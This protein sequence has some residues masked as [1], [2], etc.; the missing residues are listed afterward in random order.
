MSTIIIIILS[1]IA[2]ACCGFIF[3]PHIMRYCQQHHIYDIPN[4]RKIHK[5]NIPRL[6][7]ISFLPSMLLAFIIGM[8]VLTFVSENQYPTISLWSCMFLVSLLLIYFM[9]IVD[10]LIGLGANIKF[11]GQLIASLLMPLAGLYLNNLYGLFGVYQLPMYV[12]I[13]VTVLAIVFICNAINLIDGIDG[14][15]SSLCFLALGG[16]LWLF[17]SDGL[18]VYAVMIAGMMGAL[19]PFAYYNLF[20]DIEKNMKVF[21]GDS[22]SLTLGF[23]LGFLFVKYSMNNLS[24]M[25]YRPDALIQAASLLIVPCFDVFRIVFVRYWHHRSLFDADKNHIHHKLLRAGLT[26]HQTLFVVL[27]L[28]AFF[29]L[30]NNYLRTCTTSTVI[31][32]ADIVLFFVFHEV[33][34][35]FVRLAGR[36]PF[37]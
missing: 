13:P 6:G 30:L 26:G 27:V 11:F 14:L 15:S 29:V 1:F 36:K 28:A 17:M 18:F 37:E 23:I 34:N 2:S 7:G 24:V 21:M 8:G 12:G 33:V 9:G 4:D 16:F 22:G 31:L 3:M 10:D 19:V 25:Q 20:G 35:H 5:N 32:L